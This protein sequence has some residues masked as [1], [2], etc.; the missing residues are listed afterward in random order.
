MR[1]LGLFILLL[2]ASLIFV[3]YVHA[4]DEALAEKNA[5][6]AVINRDLDKVIQIANEWKEQSRTKTIPYF[7]L[8]HAYYVKGDYRKVTQ[9]LDFIDSSDK[10]EFLLG[11]TENF[12]RE[13][14]NDSI[15][16]ILKGDACVRLKDYDAAIR[17]FNI[18]EG[19]EPALY[20]VYAS[21]GMAYALY[22]S[23][24]SAIKSF[25]DAIRIKPDFAD[26]YYS[27][28]IVYYSRQDYSQALSDFNQA[29][30]INPGFGLAYL[31]RARAYQCLEKEDSALED[32]KK[33][34]ELNKQGFSLS[35]ESQKN[36]LAGKVSRKFSLNLETAP[37]KI[38]IKT[39]FV[40]N[41]L[42]S[43]SLGSVKGVDSRPEGKITK[44][45]DKEV[46]NAKAL[47]NKFIAPALYFLLHNSQ[48]FF[49]AE[50]GK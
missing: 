7:L 34:E 9:A 46:E 37:S 6:Y 30:R 42:I 17:E 45:T 28:G 20:L 18:A 27:R 31:A 8:M 1:K 15:P 22:N 10:K 49:K 43:G 25:G 47:D 16:Y 13:Y 50:R 4:F 26:A 39:P 12:I 41:P 40:K 14:P 19:L 21:K 36:P 2:S 29:I 48:F 11:W 24:D 32:Y 23:F 3:S 35:F 5:K 44:I 33:A 38:G